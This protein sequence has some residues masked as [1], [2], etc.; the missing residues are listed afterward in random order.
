MKITKRQL[1]RI[2]KEAV[3]GTHPEYQGLPQSDIDYYEEMDAL[4]DNA[5][6][7]LPELANAIARNKKQAASAADPEQ[8]SMHE[9]DAADLQRIYDGSKE[10]LDIRDATPP[11]YVTDKIHRLDT[12]VREQIPENLYNWIVGQR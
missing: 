4:V 8:A 9:E 11:A 12:M 3:G 7:D 2:I 1:R 6:A 5:I 10:T